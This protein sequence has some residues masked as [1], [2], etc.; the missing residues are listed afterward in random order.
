MHDGNPTHDIAMHDDNPTHDIATPHRNPNTG[1][2]LLVPSSGPLPCALVERTG[3][4]ARVHAQR[5]QDPDADSGDGPHA[6]HSART[7]GL[8]LHTAV[9]HGIAG[10]V[11]SGQQPSGAGSRVDETYLLSRGLHRTETEREAE[12][13]GGQDDREFGRHAAALV[14]SRPR[15]AHA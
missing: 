15:T 3:S 7:L 9:A 5:S 10:V 8:E 4:R 1:R 13:H 12:Q 11:A 6:D 2:G 14:V